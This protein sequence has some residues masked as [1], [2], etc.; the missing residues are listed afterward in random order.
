MK[1][2]TQNQANTVAW[3]AKRNGY[4]ARDVFEGGV[5]VKWEKL[6]AWVFANMSFTQASDFINLINADKVTEALR[7]LPSAKPLEAL[8]TVVITVTDEFGN[9]ER[10][11]TSVPSIAIEQA[12][13]MIEKMRVSYESKF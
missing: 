13:R 4:E 10:F 8:S 7:M 11:E 9:K 6:G 2:A 3:L 1:S 12:Y 5:N